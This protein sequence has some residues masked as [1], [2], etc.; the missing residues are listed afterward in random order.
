LEEEKIVVENMSVVSEAA[1]RS[2]EGSMKLD[3]E[4]ENK[5]SVADTN[6]NPQMRHRRDCH[7][8]ESTSLAAGGFVEAG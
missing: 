7:R 3:T 8:M 4:L 1:E 6:L 5:D 2:G